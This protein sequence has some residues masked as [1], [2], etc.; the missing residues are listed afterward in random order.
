MATISSLGIGS[1]LD[2][3]GLLSDLESAERQKLTPIANKQASYEAELSAWG[4]IQS[5][6]ESLDTAA[7][8]LADPDIYAGMTTTASGSGVS[9]SATN[10]AEPGSYSVSVSQLAQAQS[11][12]TG[13]QTHRDEAIGSGTATTLTLSLG[14]LGSDD[15]YVADAE[16]TAEIVIDSS[17]NSLEGIRDAINAAGLEVSASIVNDGS[18]SPYR[19][20]LTSR[21]TGKDSVISLSTSGEEPALEDLLGFDPTAPSASQVEQVVEPLD[22]SFSVNGIAMHSTSNEI[23]DAVDGLSL[24]LSDV[25]TTPSTVTVAENPDKASSAL[26]AFV[27]AYNELQKT[28]DNYT[29]FNADEG[30]AGELLGD[31]TLRTIESRLTS[32]LNFTSEGDFYALSS[33][34]V[35]RTDDGKLEFDSAMVDEADATQLAAMSG[36]FISDSEAGSVGFASQMAGLLDQV[37]GDDGTLENTTESIESSL[38]SLESQYEQTETT[39]DATIERYREQFTALDILVANLTSTSDYLTGQLETLENSWNLTD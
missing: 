12:A 8:S 26:Q 17:N 13:G 28:I 6:L 29:A 9:A 21:E 33:L 2:L 15:G 14:S 23:D 4:T 35:T 10:T 5:R 16:R 19:L 34:G 24:V 32:A 7:A 11:L 18:D 39:I 3:N 37:V 31:S 30:T 25:T 1:G 22:A 36:F 38:E 20:V 27:T